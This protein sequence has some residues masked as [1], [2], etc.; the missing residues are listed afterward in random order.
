MEI[1]PL[2]HNRRDF[3]KTLAL[4][5]GALAWPG[6]QLR[7]RERADSAERPP[8]FVLVLIDDLGWKDTGVTGTLY[9]QTPNIDAIAKAGMI[10]D[11]AYS[12]APVCSPSRG[13]LLS[14]RNPA[15]NDLTTVIRLTDPYGGLHEITAP[16]RGNRQTYEGYNRQVLPLEEFTIAEALGEGGYATALYGKW[17]CGSHERFLP[18]K[19]GFQET[20]AFNDELRAAKATK[21]GKC[22]GDVKAIGAMTDAS[23]EF[24]KKHRDR[25]FFLMLSHYA[26]HNPLMAHPDLIEKYKSLPSTDQNNPVFAGL[27]ET[28]DKSIGRL[29]KAMDELGLKENTVFIFASDNGGLSLHSTSNYPLLGGKS[30]PYEAAM[31]TPFFIRWPGRVEAGRRTST[32]VIHMDLYP[33][34]LEMAGLPARPKQHLDGRSLLPLLKGSEGFPERPLFFH[35]PHY[36]HATGPFSSI[37]AEDWKLIRWYSDTSGAYSLFNLKED[38]YELEDLSERRPDKVKQLSRRLEKFLEESDAQLPRPNPDYDPSQPPFQDKRYA[39][40]LALKERK[41]AERR[42]A[43]YNKKHNR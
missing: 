20:N 30:F 39:R 21:D 22:T 35:S 34:L 3:L 9:Y 4:G 14:G 28:L 10:F 13:A 25:P 23:I 36:T 42:L 41:E 5:T 26:M 8:N 24:M 19:Q 33:T 29:D 43:E 18:D 37:I 17:H 2:L 16:R 38:P 32:R 11:Q 27:L 1:K 31:R 40:E 15:R 7:G 6:L 12:A